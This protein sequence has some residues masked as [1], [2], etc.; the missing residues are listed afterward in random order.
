MVSYEFRCMDADGEIRTSRYEADCIKE[1]IDL[2]EVMEAP[3][4]TTDVFDEEI[5][6]R[7]AQ[8]A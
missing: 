5:E 7:R 3:Y 2:M 8:T 6:V 4:L 1:L